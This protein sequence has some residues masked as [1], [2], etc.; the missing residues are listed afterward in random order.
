MRMR[1]RGRPRVERLRTRQGQP[2]DV[3]EGRAVR[4]RVPESLLCKIILSDNGGR[5]KIKK[6]IYHFD[7]DQQQ[8]CS[9]NAA[10]A[11]NKLNKDFLNGFQYRV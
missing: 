11:D 6:S 8:R 3:C 7:P 2:R 4:S 1:G 10:S 5:E 9:P